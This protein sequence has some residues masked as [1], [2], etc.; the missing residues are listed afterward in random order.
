MKVL[1]LGVGMQ[2][3]ATLFDLVRC[4][5]FDEIV[6]ADTDLE[7]LREFHKQQ[8]FGTKVRLEHIDANDDIDLNRLFSERPDVVL[9]LLPACFV[10]KVAKAAISN[11]VNLVNTCF[12]RPELLKLEQAAIDKGVAILP[13]FGLDPGIDLLLLGDAVNKLDEVRK[14]RS[15]GAGL[16]EPAISLDNPLRYKATWTMEGVLTAYTREACV[17]ADGRP[18]QIASRDLFNPENLHSVNVEGVGELEAYPN[19]DSIKLA[20]KAGLNPSR[21]THVGCYTMRWPG[22]SAFW[23]PLVDLNMLDD[24]EVVVD[25]IGVSKR[26]FLASALQPIVELK[27][28]ERDVVIIRIEVTGLKDSRQVTIVNQMID[29]RDLK[30]GFTAMN[31]T[32]GFTASIGAQL[33]ATG[34]IGKKGIVSTMKDIPFDTVR[35][36]LLER[37]IVFTETWTE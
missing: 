34:G 31:R 21:L 3:K 37:G 11:G 32:V 4:G 22:H 25:G 14:I 13:E 27:D 18:E 2:G 5:K 26:K 12:V 30:T 24:S 28:R 6:A 10:E 29:Y 36:A 16:P 9:D 1:L 7:G 15:Y 17:L 19:G 8:S 35:R 23:K 33:I 20:A